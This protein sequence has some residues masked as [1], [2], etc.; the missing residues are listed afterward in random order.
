MTTGQL[1]AGTT[2]T[3]MA[4]AT[5]AAAIATSGKATIS[6]GVVASATDVSEMGLGWGP[7]SE[8]R[9]AVTLS[10]K[11]VVVAAAEAQN[12]SSQAAV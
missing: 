4:T 3:A 10:E 9:G 7:P 1:R 6:A 2:T 5:A 11:N 12:G 8:A